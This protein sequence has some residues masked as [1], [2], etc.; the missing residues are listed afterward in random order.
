ML[1]ADLCTGVL[2]VLLPP[3][4][5]RHSSSI[6]VSLLRC[7]ITP[8]WLVPFLATVVAMGTRV[9]DNGDGVGECCLEVLAR[10]LVVADLVTMGELM[11]EESRLWVGVPA[12]GV[13]LAGRV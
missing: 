1:V 12:E 4:S 13:R 6:I 8:V 9:L 2:R 10:L 3:P 7:R 5:F 11:A